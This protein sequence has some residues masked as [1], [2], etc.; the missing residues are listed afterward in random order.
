MTARTRLLAFG[1]ILLAALAGCEA[2]SPVDD[3]AANTQARA[4]SIT[5]DFHN[6]LMRLQPMYQRLA[7]KRAITDSRYRCG[8]VDNAGFQQDY[9]P[10]RSSA[11]SLKMW[12]GHCA[13]ENRNYAV[14]I[15]PNGDVQVRYCTDAGTLS[16]PPCND[17]PPAT[18]TGIGAPGGP[19]RNGA[20]NAAANTAL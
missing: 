13:P 2:P 18:D 15:A 20:G 6:Q 5:N 17:L 8:R 11:A 14:F 19:S 3:S 16:L 1:P 9:R 7:M 4:I 12:V 10:E